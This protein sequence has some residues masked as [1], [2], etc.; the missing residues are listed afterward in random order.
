MQKDG[1]WPGQGQLHVVM[2]A[3][4]R[5]CYRSSLRAAT[6]HRR[7]WEGG[8][9]SGLRTSIQGLTGRSSTDQSGKE[10]RGQSEGGR[11]TREERRKK[12]RSE[13]PP[14]PALSLQA[15]LPPSPRDRPHTPFTLLHPRLPSNPLHPPTA[16]RPPSPWTALTPPSPLTS[17]TPR[18]PSLL[19]HPPS[20][21][22]LHPGTACFREAGQAP[23]TTRPPHR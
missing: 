11:E 18:L 12:V 23:Q 7:W 3:I 17:F 10:K 15:R 6:G 22:P 14:A 5:S 1:T 8:R 21:P 19:L 20:S 16:R 2:E 4:T 9:S 13:A